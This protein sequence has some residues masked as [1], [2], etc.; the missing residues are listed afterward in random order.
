MEVLGVK[1]NLFL[2]TFYVELLFENPPEYDKY[3]ILSRMENSGISVE[4]ANDSQEFL[5]FA[6]PE[7][8]QGQKELE[9]CPQCV[10]VKK[11]EIL[12]ENSYKSSFEQ[13]WDWPEKDKSLRKCKYKI[14]F[15][16]FLATNLDNQF[17]IKHF[18][19]CLISVLDSMNCTAIHW[20]TSMRLTSA[21]H[22]KNIVSREHQKDFLFGA[23]NVRLFPMNEHSGEFLMD[24]MGLGA[25]NLPDLQCYL[26]KTDIK[27]ISRV[28]TNYGYY[29]FENGNII[30]NGD[31][32][33]GIHEKQSWV[34]GLEGSVMKPERSVITLEL[35]CNNHITSSKSSMHRLHPQ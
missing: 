17:R 4:I 32:I 22:Y 3:K 19:N 14:I 18:N 33:K 20:V 21:V 9:A 8:V 6:F 7:L 10:I 16:D 5:S 13:T 34:C 15:S 23:L 12:E 28:L 24:T 30:Q 35:D 11:S 27:D 31:T 29:L 25:F 26:K 2:P 1:D